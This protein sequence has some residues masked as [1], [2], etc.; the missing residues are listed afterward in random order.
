MTR[1]GAGLAAALLV[2]GTASAAR[3]TDGGP[4][5]FAPEDVLASYDSPD[6]DLRVHYSALGPNAAPLADADADGVPDHVA[7]VAATA[8]EALERFGEL[9]LRAPLGEAE[10]D[11]EALGGSAA[12][13]VYLVDFG[14]AAD[15]L[16]GVDGCA[17]T[18]ACAGH[19]VIENDFAGYGYASAAEAV[20]TVVS[21][22]L[23]HAVQAAYL[24]GLPLY[25]SEGTAVWAERA[26][27]PE[28]R[29]F[30]RFCDKYLADTGRSLDRPPSGPVP[31]FAYGTALWWDFLTLRH[32]ASLMHALLVA[33]S[34]GEVLP[35]LRALLEAREDRLDEAWL[36][37]AAWNLATG[38]RATDDGYPYAAELDGVAPEQEG[39]AIDDDDRF[40]P[41]S[42]RYYRVEHAGGPLWFGL[43]APAPGLHLA[44][45]A[46]ALEPL[47]RWEGTESGGR[48][49]AELEAGSYWISAANPAVGTESI[50]A[51]VCT[52]TSEAALGCVE[53]VEEPEPEPEQPEP[54]PEP[55]PETPEEP[56]A[57]SDADTGCS[58]RANDTDGGAWMSLLLLV[59][60][61][62]RRRRR[63]QA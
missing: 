11:L 51:H 21:H 40:F 58:C 14:G 3:P 45:Y 18:G 8:A 9:G 30:L 10:L 41:L 49:L 63:P 60:G 57:E 54:E 47:V 16:F 62:T 39:A 6:A 7:R 26:F 36:D 59:P 27:R 33:A 12:L 34:E 56:E 2:P 42:A 19:L 25:V 31:A 1:A 52:G 4:W 43:A 50:R 46:D 24:G 53:L 38:S 22:E 28:S 17:A 44:L 15:G 35:G 48:A 32:D 20:D 55:E 61:L 37:F 5:S 13:D 29:D 23:F